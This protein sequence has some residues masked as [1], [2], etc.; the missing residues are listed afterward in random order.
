V[1]RILRATSGWAP[2]DRTLQRLFSRLELSCPAGEDSQL[3]FGRFEAA[4]P[5]ELWTGD[6]LHGPVIGGRKTYL[7]CFIDDYS[8]A[9]MGARWAFHE[10]VVRLAAALR[11]AL[12]VRGVPESAYVDN[13]SAFVDAWLLRACAVLGIKLVHSRPGRPPLTGQSLDRL[14]VP[15]LHPNRPA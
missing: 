1:Q 8:R 15:L 6:A 13:G 9:V 5:N 2:S 12:A 7:F 4:R 14:P 11:P 3:V 10:D